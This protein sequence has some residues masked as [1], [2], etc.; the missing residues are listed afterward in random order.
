MPCGCQQKNF[1][2]HV[3]SQADYEYLKRRLWE[4]GQ[5]TFYFIIRLITGYGSARQRACGISGGG[6]PKGI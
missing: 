1:L 3:I 4:D 5:Y 6:R 2:D